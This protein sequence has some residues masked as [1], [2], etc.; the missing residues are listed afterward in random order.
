MALSVWKGSGTVWTVIAEDQQT[1]A[2]ALTEFGVRI[3]VAGGEHIGLRMPNPTPDCLYQ[4]SDAGD[5]IGVAVAA[6]IGS[7]VAITPVS[8]YRFNVAVDVEPDGDKDG[9]GDETQDQCPGNS[10]TAGPCPDV[11]PPVTTIG[12]HP[13]RKSAKR[14]ARFTFT[15]NEPGARFEC[16]LDKGKF[17]PCS[18]PFRRKLGVGRHKF[19]VRSVDAAG[20]VDATPAK[21]SWKILEG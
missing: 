14:K 6:P 16:K 13:A 1:I 20:N 5:Q 12:K 18:S 3:P 21:F 11:I 4:T 15:A 19:S 17:R 9:Y 10:A 8:G 2:G 7:P